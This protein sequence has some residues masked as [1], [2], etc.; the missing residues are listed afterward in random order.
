[1]ICKICNELKVPL[2]VVHAKKTHPFQYTGHSKDD[3]R[4]HFLLVHC[5]GVE[6][7]GAGVIQS[8]SHITESFSVGCPQHYH[9][10][11]NTRERGS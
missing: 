10:I 9:L 7:S 6:Q 8:F 4:G 3:G 5:N 2:S 11:G 1:M